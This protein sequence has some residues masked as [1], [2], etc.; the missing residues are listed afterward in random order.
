MNPN[1]EYFEQRHKKSIKEYS[2]ILRNRLNDCLA[3]FEMKR[4]ML[5]IVE[6]EQGD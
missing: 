5:I 1:Q 6:L 3:D 2:D 4:F